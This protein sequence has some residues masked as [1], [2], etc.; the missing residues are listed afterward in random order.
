MVNSCWIFAP[1]LLR[2]SVL[3][4]WQRRVKGTTLCPPVKLKNNREKNKYLQ[5]PAHFRHTDTF[6]IKTV[7]SLLGESLGTNPSLRA[8]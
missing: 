4:S 2:E 3:F 1:D 5:T 8:G 6:S 7:M